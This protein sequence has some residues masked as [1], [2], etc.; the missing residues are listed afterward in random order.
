[1]FPEL[2]SIKAQCN[3]EINETREAF[4]ILDKA[5]FLFP[6]KEEF[7]LQKIVYLLDLEL[8]QEAAEQS[9]KFIGRFGE[10]SGAYLTIG[11]AFKRAR[12]WESAIKIL[13]MA[14]L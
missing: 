13:E 5:T 11:E 7:R 8:N 6:D 3:W 1:M 12:E 9:R 10:K 4:R 14:K 2:L